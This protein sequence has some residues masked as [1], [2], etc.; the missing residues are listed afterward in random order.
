MTR[1]HALHPGGISEQLLFLPTLQALAAQHYQ[2][3]VVVPPDTREVYQLSSAVEQT[4]IFNFDDSVGLADWSNLFGIVREREHDVVITP[5]SDTRI[6]FFLWL[7][8]IP[9]RIG[10]QGDFGTFL[11]SDLV[12]QNKQQALFLN[13]GEL[14]KPLGLSLSSPSIDLQVK[15]SDQKWF[16]DLQQSLPLK[17]DQPLVLLYDADADGSGANR[18]EA[19]TV[20]ASSSYSLQNWGAVLSSLGDR[21]PH[22]QVALLQYGR[23]ESWIES[24]KPMVAGSSV[25]QATTLGQAA[26]AIEAA[27]WFVSTDHA[28][29]YLG[30]G[31]STNVLGLFGPS[32][33][34]KRLPPRDQCK[35]L[36][37]ASGQLNDIP[38]I[39]IL[40]N[41]V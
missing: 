35:G 7:L 24:C 36:R 37:A 22:A 41:L 26:A 38:P 15:S 34:D 40:E 18:S 10:T 19:N 27:Q 8:G 1:L 29:L 9:R 39:Q 3:D 5:R 23:N 25:I 30:S 11:M 28:P 31:S 14:L 17:P 33:P 4:I 20:S 32:S 21:L 16:A 12:P 13:Y 6:R 2:I